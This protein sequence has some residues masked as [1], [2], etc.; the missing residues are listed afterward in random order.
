MGTQEGTLEVRSQNQV[1]VA[2]LDVQ[3]RRVLLD[4]CVVD[5]DIDPIESLNR[6][7][8]QGVDFVR[9]GDVDRARVRRPPHRF[10][11]LGHIPGRFGASPEVHARDTRSAPRQ[12]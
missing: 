3:E 7:F 5:Q 1:P 6:G 12:L 11:L 10:Q 2:L 8:H 4:S 9:S